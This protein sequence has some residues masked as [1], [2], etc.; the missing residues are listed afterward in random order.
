MSFTPLDPEVFNTEEVTLRCMDAILDT[1][2][3]YGFAIQEGSN[4]QIVDALKPVFDKI[5]GLDPGVSD[6]PEG[7]VGYPYQALAIAMAW[8]WRMERANVVNQGKQDPLHLPTMMQSVEDYLKKALTK[9]PHPSE[10]L[11]IR[12]VVELDRP[13]AGRF[14]LDFAQAGGYYSCPDFVSLHEDGTPEKPRYVSWTSTGEM[15][16]QVSRHLEA[17]ERSKGAL[18]TLVNHLNSK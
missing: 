1:L 13:M 14:T 9:D 10:L 8:A 15:L 4:V 12:A 17:I 6:K 2:A 11:P 16:T 3:S 18:R 7:R 5:L